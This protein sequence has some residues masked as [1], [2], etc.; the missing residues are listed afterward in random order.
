MTAKSVDLRCPAPVVGAEGQYRAKQ[1]AVVPLGVCNEH[2]L[3]PEGK[4]CSGLHRNMQRQ[5][6]MTCPVPFGISNKIDGETHWLGGEYDN[7]QRL[8]ARGLDL[9]IDVGTI[10]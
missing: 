4:M 5:A 3:S 1:V 7:F 9:L 8:L 6:E 10:N 2:G